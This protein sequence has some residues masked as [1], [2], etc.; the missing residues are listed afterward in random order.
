MARFRHGRVL[1]AGDAAHQVSPFGARGAN[2]GV[3]DADNL[4]WKLAL[5]AARRGAGAAARHLLRRARPAADE[6]ILNSTRST[7]FITPK[8]AMSRTFRDAVLEL[9]ARHPFARRLVNSGRLSVPATLRARRSTRPT[10]TRS[11]ARW[12]PARRRPTRRSP[13][14]AGRRGS[15]TI[16]AARSRWCTSARPTCRRRCR[17]AASTCGRPA[18]R[19]RPARRAAGLL[20]QRYD[21]ATEPRTCSGPTSMSVRAGGD[22]IRLESA[23]P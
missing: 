15:S 4:A 14:T 3:Q 6:N 11:A 2:S 23:R 1:F 13:S 7:D 16:S 5:R 18:G 20:A 19:P 22:T 8:S 10:R 21:A 12:R 17:A 9:A